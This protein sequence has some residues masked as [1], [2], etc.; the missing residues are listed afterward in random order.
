MKP[1]DL[2]TGEA[3]TASVV[4]AAGDPP[5]A[6][7]IRLAVIGSTAGN[8]H[9]FSWSA[10][11]NGYDHEVM[12]R[13]CPFAGI[14]AYLSKE[15]AE[16]LRLPGAE[17][18]HIYCK[19]DGEFD[20]EQVAACTGIRTVV[21]RPEDV[22]GEVDAVLVATDNGSE[23]V[24]QCR[25]FVEAGLPVYVD[26]PLVDTAADLEVFQNWVDDGHLLLSS[27]CMR[28]AKE[29]MPF[30]QSTHDLGDIRFASITTPKSWERYGIHA[31][32]TIYPILGPGFHSVRNTG[33]QNRNVVHL[34]HRSGADVVVVANADM[35][36][37]LGC[38]QLCGTV[39]HA[40]ASFS[41][42]LYAFKA[43]LADFLTFIRSGVRPYPF[44]ETA[45][46][47][48]LLI[49]GMKSRENGGIE[50]EVNG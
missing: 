41:D 47:M 11:L 27:S 49:A 7:A 26:K 33:S 45:E 4:D 48:T 6:R 46:L 16:G 24:S 23:H 37:G 40:H 25:P 43:Q 8:G 32:E 35:S 1:L 20:A 9:P 10:I 42:S 18:T 22:I 39:G 13:E 12:T 14:P 3:S 21:Q 17:V 44:R 38:L 19:G 30:R 15:P 2:V 29:F 5:D 34:K 36:G 31:L 50:L 28:Y